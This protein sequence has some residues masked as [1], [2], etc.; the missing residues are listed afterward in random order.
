MKL[1]PPFAGLIINRFDGCKTG[2]IVDITV[3]SFGIKKNWVS[4]ITEHKISENEAIF[5]DT[6]IKL[7]PPLKKWQHLHKIEKSIDS[8]IIFDDISYETGSKITDLLIFP[9]L[10]LAFYSRKP[11]Y[12]KYFK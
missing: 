2:D 11:V 5:V 7:P 8:S 3:S 12:R 10:F 6:G 9:L 4:E 1:K